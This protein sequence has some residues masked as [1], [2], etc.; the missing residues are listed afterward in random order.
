MASIYTGRVK[1]RR[2]LFHNIILVITEKGHIY[3][4]S[5]LDRCHWLTILLS[6][7]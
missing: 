1:S 5:M 4:N 3:K 7:A 6:T 2:M